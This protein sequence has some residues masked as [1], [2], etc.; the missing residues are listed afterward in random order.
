MSGLF[1]GRQPKAPFQLRYD[2]RLW[3]PAT[4]SGEEADAERIIPKMITKALSGSMTPQ[5]AVTW[6]EAE[7]HRVMNQQ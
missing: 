7:M 4:C 5:Q 3:R 6:A 1:Y 2:K